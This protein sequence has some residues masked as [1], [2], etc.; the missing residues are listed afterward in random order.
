MEDMPVSSS[1]SLRTS[2]GFSW[3]REPTSGHRPCRGAFTSDSYSRAVFRLR[4]AVPTRAGPE[5]GA[6]LSSDRQGRTGLPGPGWPEFIFLRPHS[7]TTL[8]PASGEGTGLLPIINQMT[9]HNFLADFWGHE[10]QTGQA[11]P[12]LGKMDQ[13]RVAGAG[14]L[15][16]VSLCNPFSQILWPH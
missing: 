3:L 15:F 1:S 10:G 6:A 12:I 4:A 8:A 5:N 11:R 13:A 2:L 16:G 7:L 9:R 14:A